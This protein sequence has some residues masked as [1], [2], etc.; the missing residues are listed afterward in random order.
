VEEE[1]GG[2]RT[3][4]LGIALDLAAT[5]TC[6]QLECPGEPGC[7]DAPAPVSLADEVAGDPPVRQGRDALLLCGPVLDLRPLVRR[8]ALPPTLPVGAL[9]H[10]GRMRRALPHPCEL[11][12][13]VERGIAAVIRMKAHA[14]AAPEHAVVR[15][16]Q[17]GERIPARLVESPNRVR[18]T[19]D[20]LSLA[21]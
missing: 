7:G 21:S 14:P 17:G 20:R 18:R 5:Q 16:D 19:H 11:A 9:E 3:R 4:A 2:N 10:Q 15:L 8:A 12:F 1:A 6:N 13:P